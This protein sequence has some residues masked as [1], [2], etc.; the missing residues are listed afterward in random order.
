MFIID[1]YCSIILLRIIIHATHNKQ[2]NEHLLGSYSSMW[3][4]MIIFMPN[5]PYGQYVR[6]VYFYSSMQIIILSNSSL[7]LSPIKLKY[8]EY[9]YL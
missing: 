1:D 4:N 3:Q 9:V 6:A 8:Y 7:T 2:N 5:I